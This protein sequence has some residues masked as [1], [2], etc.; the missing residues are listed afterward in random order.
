MSEFNSLNIFNFL[1]NSLKRL[2]WKF[3]PGYWSS[4]CSWKN[5]NPV[6]YTL[7]VASDAKIIIVPSKHISTIIHL[8]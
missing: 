2:Y 5:D 8:V 4:V 7:D 3:K 1:F 6:I